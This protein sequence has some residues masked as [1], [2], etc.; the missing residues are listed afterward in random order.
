MVP[1]CGC[2]SD[3]HALHPQ[4]TAYPQGTDAAAY[5]RNAIA[6]TGKYTLCAYAECK[7][8]YLSDNPKKASIAECGCWPGKGENFGTTPGILGAI[9]KNKTAATC[10]PPA[11]GCLKIPDKAPMCAAQQPGPNGKAAIYGG[12]YDLISTFSPTGW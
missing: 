3:T 2:S 8:T 7:I 1:E 5:I 6:C 11:S 10:D 9:A 4:H 12:S